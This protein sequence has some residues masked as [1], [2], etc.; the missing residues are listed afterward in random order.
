MKMKTPTRIVCAERMTD[1]IVVTFEDGKCAIFST[2][3]MYAN[4]RYAEAITE[5]NEEETS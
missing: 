4:L 2:A 1:G 5:K 3:F